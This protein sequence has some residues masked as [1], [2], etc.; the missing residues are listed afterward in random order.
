MSHVASVGRL[1]TLLPR[2][3]RCVFEVTESSSQTNHIC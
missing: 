1:K 2:Y 3:A